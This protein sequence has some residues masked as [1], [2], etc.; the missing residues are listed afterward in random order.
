MHIYHIAF[1]KPYIGCDVYAEGIV[2]VSPL[3][4]FLSIYC[5]YRLAHSSIEYQDGTLIAFRSCPVQLVHTL[6]YPWECTRATRLLSL[7]GLS[8]LF[9][10]HLLQVPFL[11]ERT[12]YCPVV[13]H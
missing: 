8:I 10:S 1:P 6:A 9:D 4:R 7:L 2:A 11:I 12:R 3:A 5:D 13:R